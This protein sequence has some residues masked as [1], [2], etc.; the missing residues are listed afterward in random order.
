MKSI[1]PKIKYLLPPAFP[2]SAPTSPCEFRR[3]HCRQCLKLV[4]SACSSNLWKLDSR[5]SRGA[6]GRRTG[7]KR[8]CDECY[9]TLVATREVCIPM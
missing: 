7:A 6:A 9:A 3:H 5:R 1:P 4:C 8:V 2:P